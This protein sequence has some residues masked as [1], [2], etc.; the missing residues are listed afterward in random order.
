MKC[1]Y[2]SA[3]KMMDLSDQETEAFYWCTKCMNEVVFNKVNG[4][5]RVYD[6]HGRCHREG[7][8]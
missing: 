8:W 7:A 6:Q 5:Y 1:P 3:A 2:C 4:R